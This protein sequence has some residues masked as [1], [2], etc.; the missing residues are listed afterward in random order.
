MMIQKRLFI[1]ALAMFALAG[2]SASAQESQQNDRPP[3]A[4]QQQQQQRRLAMLAQKLNLTDEQRRQWMEIQHQTVQKVRAARKDDSLNEEQ[5]QARLREIHREQREQ[6]MALL[7]QE[8]QDELKAFWAEQKQKQQEKASDNS[9]PAADSS[10]Q[11]GDAGKEK[12]AD[13]FAGMTSDDPAPQ[14]PQTKK[15]AHK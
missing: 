7:T 9:A 10:A 15:A 5:M 3:Q 8:Q 13:L 11:N 1:A 2:L 12:D 6:V 14:P 4:R